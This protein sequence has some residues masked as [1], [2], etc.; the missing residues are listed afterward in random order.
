[1]ITRK[2]NLSMIKIY[3]KHVVFKEAATSLYQFLRENKCDCTITHS[4]NS[5]DDDMYILFGAHECVE[6]LPKHYIVYQLEQTRTTVKGMQNNAIW[7]PRYINILHQAHSV[8]D[9]SRSNIKVLRQMFRLTNLKYVPLS[10]ASCLH[11]ENVSTQ[12]SSED[13]IDILF[14]G[15]HSNRREKYISVLREKMPQ[16]CRIVWEKNSVW[17]KERAALVARSKLILNIHHSN[18]AILEIPRILYAVCQKKCVISER[19]RYQPTNKDWDAAV[20]F[21]NTPKELV[22]SCTHFLYTKKGQNELKTKTSSA[23]KY[24][25]TLSFNIPDAF[26]KEYM[27]NNIEEQQ[28][29]E[30]LPNKRKKRRKKRKHAWYIPLPVPSAETKTDENGFSLVLPKI[31]DADLPTVSVVTPTRN[32]RHLFSLPLRNWQTTIYPKDKIEWVIMDDGDDDLKDLIPSNDERIKYTK[33][34]TGGKALSIGQKRNLCCSMMANNDIIVFMD[35]DDYYVPEHV[36]SRVKTLLQYKK[37]GVQ[38]VGCSSMGAYDLTTDKSSFISNGKEF[39]TESTM[40]FWKSFWTSRNFHSQDR[41]GEYAHFLRYRQPVMKHIPYQFVSVAFFHGQN[42]S[43]LSR[44]ITQNVGSYHTVH[45]VVDEDTGWFLK[46]LRKKVIK[47]DVNINKNKK[48]QIK[49]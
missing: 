29:Q 10:Y 40:A 6:K 27:T 16:K 30:E 5:E 44:K 17:N 22:R 24:V 28:T 2:S 9:F 21:I 8:W 19:G 13:N 7:T 43:G 15:S 1:M 11:D 35:D 20:H 14:F 32:R 3:A 49:K 38:C 42:S 12:N 37:E 41:S 36:L 25:K 39:F 4:I 34:D 33:L 23:L 46:M 31:E 47:Y 18:S 45:D 26:K 48:H